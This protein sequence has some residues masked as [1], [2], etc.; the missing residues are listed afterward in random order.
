MVEANIDE[1]VE[2]LNIETGSVL[3][4]VVTGAF[5]SVVDDLDKRAHAHFKASWAAE[6]KLIGTLVTLAST[7]DRTINF[8]G[9]YPFVSARLA[10]A[11][12]H[13]IA[14]VMPKMIEKEIDDIKAVRA[15]MTNATKSAVAVDKL[16]AAKAGALP[17]MLDIYQEAMEAKAAKLQGAAAKDA[18]PA[19]AVKVDGGLAWRNADMPLP[20]RLAAARGRAIADQL[21]A[22]MA[23]TDCTACGYDCEGYAKAIAEGKEKDLTKCVPGEAETADALKKIVASGAK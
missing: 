1:L 17:E 4:Y 14:G 19:K 16:L 8:D 5:P 13:H 11:Q 22:A 6:S 23:Q 3:N 7:G 10:Y 20:E 12:A 2:I 21:W 9:V 18:K 15:R